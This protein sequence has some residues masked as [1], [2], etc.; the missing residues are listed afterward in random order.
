M[1]SSPEVTLTTVK[2]P[3]ETFEEWGPVGMGGLES[4]EGT[5][6]KNV[7]FFFGRKKLCGQNKSKGLGVSYKE[8]E[9]C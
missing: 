8:V 9:R 2:H 5:N 7:G 6:K 4:T 1:F 3:K